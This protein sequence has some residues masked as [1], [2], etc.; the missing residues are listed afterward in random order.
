MNNLKKTNTGIML[1]LKDFNLE[2]IAKVPIHY[3]AK[4]TLFRCIGEADSPR[5]GGV[6]KSFFDPDIYRKE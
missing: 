4:L 3:N 1:Y 5:V 6:P 2:V